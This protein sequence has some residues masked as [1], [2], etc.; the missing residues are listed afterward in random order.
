MRKV[1]SSNN[2]Y[3]TPKSIFNYPPSFSRPMSGMNTSSLFTQRIRKSS[4]KHSRH[5]KC[6][7]STLNSSASFMSVVSSISKEVLYEETLS[8]KHEMNKLINQISLIKSDIRKKE[9]DLLLKDKKI[10]EANSNSNNNEI[11]NQDKFDQLIDS[12]NISKIKKAF[13]QLK[14]EYQKLKDKNSIAKHSVRYSKLNEIQC[15]IEHIQ[16]YLSD[17]ITKYSLMQLENLALES[18]LNESIFLS[19]TFSNQHQLLSSMQNEFDE[20]KGRIDAAQKCIE[21]KNEEKIKNESIKKKL[22]IEK[23]N[24]TKNK[25]KLMNEIKNNDTFLQSKPTFLSKIKELEENV[26]Y[27]KNECR[28][29]ESMIK[30][31]QGD[32]A[33]LEKNNGKDMTKLQP[34]D[35]KR[36]EFKEADPIFKADSKVL[37]LKSLINESKQKQKRYHLKI[38]ASIQLLREFG[39]EVPSIEEINSELEKMAIEKKHINLNEI[40]PQEVI[41]QEQ[42]QIQEENG[43]MLVAKNSSEANTKLPDDISMS[44]TLLQ[45]NDT[46]DTSRHQMEQQQQI[47]NELFTEITYVII[48]NIEAQKLTSRKA[49]EK[50]IKNIKELNPLI[51]K[52]NYINQISLN[53][54]EAI[55]CQNEADMKTIRIWLESLFFIYHNDVTKVTDSFS[56]LFNNIKEYSKEEE[57]ILSK[58]LK[59]VLL[60]F[61]DK[62]KENVITN[63][64]NGI[65]SYLLLKHF[66]EEE[67]VDMKDSYGEFLFYKLKQFK[68]INPASLYDLDLKILNEVFDNDV[69]DSKM[70]AKTE[71]DIEISQEDYVRIITQFAMALRNYLSS[72]NITLKQLLNSVMQTIESGTNEPGFEVINIEVFVEEMRKIKIDI[73]TELEIYCLFNRYKISD[74]YEYL[75]VDLIENDLGGRNKYEATRQVM[76]KVLEEEE[77]SN[78]NKIE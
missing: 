69:N 71:N 8:L 60:P 70:N 52:D 33:K 22:G 21:A 27:Y 65:V 40:K 13:L 63:S 15:K 37:L 76:E 18:E 64:N 44:S 77:E 35:Y 38:Q 11:S 26:K 28:N 56:T 31:L 51:S 55:G 34:V 1:S 3:E 57:L 53:I 2:I 5:L 54:K 66:I 23:T 50:I 17:L 47:S 39:K 7:K 74:D 68:P 78:E 45:N 42:K 32:T 49:E 48:K 4:N 73:N 62:L 46:K 29:K 6:N 19:I 9:V 10:E 16:S 72:S 43:Q 67:K 59:K 61:K 24:M 12:N 30:T 58:K 25:Q 14:T 36:F 41:K 20:L 75:S